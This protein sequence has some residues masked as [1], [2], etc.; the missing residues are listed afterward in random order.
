MTKYLHFNDRVDDQDDLVKVRPIIE[1]MNERFMKASCLRVRNWTVDESIIP[2]YGRYPIVPLVVDR[3]KRSA[4]KIFCL[5]SQDGYLLSFNP[6][7]GKDGGK[8][9]N[10]ESFGL[11]SGTVLDLVQSLP[12][13][14]EGSLYIDKS[15]TPIRKLQ[16]LKRAGL[17]P[18]YLSIYNM[19][20]EGNDLDWQ[21]FRL[22]MNLERNKYDFHI[23]NWIFASAVMNAWIL[24]KKSNAR[25]AKIRLSDFITELLHYYL[26]NNQ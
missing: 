7:Q 9:N 17:F 8:T 6:Y 19:S 23:F 18:E 24:Y 5:S 10:I 1:M 25:V 2:Y 13:N 20:V 12:H 16:E 21:Q 11:G 4:F 3:R 22:P 14:I 15:F 26:P